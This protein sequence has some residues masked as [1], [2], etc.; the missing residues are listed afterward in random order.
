MQLIAFGSFHFSTVW[1]CQACCAVSALVVW[2]MQNTDYKKAQQASAENWAWAFQ[3]DIYLAFAITV[4]KAEID[5]SLTSQLA[6]TFL[7]YSCC[8]FIASV[9]MSSRFLFLLCWLSRLFWRFFFNI[10]LFFSRASSACEQS[11]GKME[12]TEGISNSVLQKTLIAIT[13]LQEQQ[14]NVIK[15][16]DLIRLHFA[17]II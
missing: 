17:S 8:L 3:T 16:T 2:V 7:S 13:S 15:Q 9:T 14:S 11:T 6:L 4:I 1:K 10:S 12:W 5:F